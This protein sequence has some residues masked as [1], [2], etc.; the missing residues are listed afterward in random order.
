[1]SV[2][3]STDSSATS[4]AINFYE[5]FLRSP[6]FLSWIRDRSD[7]MHSTNRERYLKRLQ[8]EFLRDVTM[9]MA[10]LALRP[11]A[12]AQMS[13]AWAALFEQTCSG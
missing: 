4:T 6:N 8:S 9:L 1:M 3:S 7:T 11:R 13:S 10:R 5:R 2:H 12:H